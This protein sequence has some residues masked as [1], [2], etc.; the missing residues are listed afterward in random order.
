MLVNYRE[1]RVA[2]LVAFALFVLV[3]LIGLPLW[4]DRHFPAHH[5]FAGR[6]IIAPAMGLFYLLLIW[7]TL[8]FNAQVRNDPRALQ[9][10]TL[11]LTLWQNGRTER[12]QWPQVG[13]V[14]IQQGRQPSYPSFLKIATRS[15]DGRQRLWRF[16]SGRLQLSGQPLGKLAEQIEQA[17]NGKVVPAAPAA[18]AVP[19]DRQAA[20][21]RYEQ[22]LGKA[23]AIV[24]IVFSIYF[25]TLAGMAVHLW[26]NTMLLT[27]HDPLLWK[28]AKIAF[29][30]TSAAILLWYVQTVR[31]LPVTS[32][33]VAL[34]FLPKV[35]VPGLFFAGMVGLWAYVAANVYVTDKTWSGHV[36]HG[37]VLMVIHEPWITHRGHVNVE[38]HLI[39][40]P[41]QDVFFALDDSDGELLKHWHDPGYIDEPA[42]ITVPVQWTGYAIRSEVTTDTLLPKGSVSTCK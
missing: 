27:P 13:D 30:A 32:W 20:N 36:E 34:W 26:D 35:M 14:S 40:R 18:S 24:A 42:C 39:D 31:S 28:A 12:V 8:R 10:D 15:A 38:A 7:R 41:G 6:T 29:I 5:G 33:R 9:W 21:E 11:G 37:S 19:P 4:A 16:S 3:C 25:V 2:P 22:R 1:Q 23:R 17:R